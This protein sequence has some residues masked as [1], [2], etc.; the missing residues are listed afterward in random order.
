MEGHGSASL[1]GAAR[2]CRMRKAGRVVAGEVS[3]S[4][5]GAAQP[6]VDPEGGV[7]RL[8]LR[9]R[10][11]PLLLAGAAVTVAPTLYVAQAPPWAFAYVVVTVLV[12]LALW[13]RSQIRPLFTRQRQAASLAMTVLGIGGLLVVLVGAGWSTAPELVMLITA[14]GAVVAVAPDRRVAWVFQVVVVAVL[15]AALGIGLGSWVIAALVTVQVVT[16]M[17]IVDRFS[18]RLF[19]VRTAEQE[20]RLAAERRGE[21]LDAVRHLPRGSVHG[22]EQAA[23]ATLRE[24]AFDVA[25]VVRVDGDHLWERVISGVAPLG[26]PVTRGQG[27]AWQAVVEDQTLVTDRYDDTTKQLPGREFLKGVVVTPI[28]IEGRPV[29]AL[30]GGRSVAR[31]PSDDEVEI[32]EVMA[33]HLGSVMANRAT[34]LRQEEL[35]EQAARLDQMGKGLLEAVSEEIRDPLTVLR[36]RAQRLMDHAADLDEDERSRLLRRLRSES[37]ELRLVI[38][39][40]LDFSRFHER[41]AEPQPEP[42]LMEPL[43]R[44][45]G[46]VVEDGRVDAAFGGGVGELVVLLDRELAVSGLVLLVAS[47]R[48]RTEQ[49]MAV[50][51]TRSALRDEIGL[52]FPAGRFARGASV[53]VGV[54]IQLL[55]SAGAR[56]EVND[57]T[58]RARLWL[59]LAP[60][61][62]DEPL[63]E[64]GR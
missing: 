19:G 53:L 10:F 56:V 49:P 54:A 44:S 16:I 47:V 34:V 35:L 58:D 36:L 43:L 45:S 61:E 14:L 5:A 32:V 26:G 23:V 46:V 25:V 33:A 37:E 3:T 42:V 51:L 41:R 39:T 22:A 1:A 57:R 29:G 27:L 21:L 15:F 40:I 38:D 7:L 4:D 6:P 52:V 30:A 50:R 2:G 48:V 63:G 8:L 9:A 18:Q 55:T 59:R 62:T 11:Q 20:A 64:V 28:R 24:L 31:R 12:G 60:E 17:L 13:A